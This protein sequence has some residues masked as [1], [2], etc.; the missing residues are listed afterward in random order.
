MQYMRTVNH[1]NWTNK[2]FRDAKQI[3]PQVHFLIQSKFKLNLTSC[4]LCIPFV[5]IPNFGDGVITYTS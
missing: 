3:S 4:L 1:Q 2:Y 5:L